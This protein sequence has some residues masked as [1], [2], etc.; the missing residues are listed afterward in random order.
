MPTTLRIRDLPAPVT[1]SKADWLAGTTWIGFTPPSGNLT[2][3]NDCT[4]TIQRQFGQGYVIEY[5]T[6][7]FSEPN[8]GF[9]RDPKY[10]EERKAHAAQAGRFIA[11]H[12]LRYSSRSLEAI[13]GE[14][15]FKRLQDMWAQGGKRWRWSVAFPIIESYRIVD[16]PKAKT[17]LGTEGYRRL[18]AHSSATLR[19][20]NST[21][22]AAL[23]DLE[24]E[25]VPASNAWIAISDEFQNAERSDIAKNTVRLIERDLADNA[26]EGMTDERKAKV[27]KRAA[28]LADRFI[29]SRSKAGRLVCDDC[30]FDP[31][32]RLPPEQV[33]PRSLLDVHHKHP[34]EEGIRYTTIHDFALLCPTCHRVEHARMKLLLKPSVTASVNRGQRQ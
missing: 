16:R 30:G 21:E 25:L 11:V 5:I 28:W 10:L 18:F 14:E 22:Q 31:T 20:L 24:L 23:G 7:Q 17:V 15:E 1:A 34:L 26:M 27:R 13:L 6:E 4:K 29:L 9:E 12:R 19:A 33:R 2:S 32:S 3:R 8:P